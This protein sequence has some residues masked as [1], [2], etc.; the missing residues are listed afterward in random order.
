M[1][2]RTVA[3]RETTGQETLE[4]GAGKARGQQAEAL[5]VAIL[6]EIG[7]RL[8]P[9]RFSIWFKRTRLQAVSD[10]EITV[11]VPNLII[12]QYIEHRYL[13]T[14]QEAAGAVLGRGVSA[15]LE[16]D[17]ALFRQMREERARQARTDRKREASRPGLKMAPPP[18]REPEP[19][20]EAEETFFV[21]EFNR[22]AHAAMLEFVQN[23]GTKFRFMAVYG[24][25]GTGKTAYLRRM[26][27]S[28]A[29]TRP[30]TNVQTLS[31]ESWTNEFFYCLQ[32]NQMAKFRRRYRTCDLLLLDDVHFLEGKKTPQ[33]ELLYTLKA[34]QSEGK[35]AVV[36]SL[37]PLV[38]LHT[39]LPG[40]YN[41][42]YSWLALGL[43]TLGFQDRTGLARELA[44][45]RD[46]T[47]T[48]ET[49]ALLAESRLSTVREIENSVTALSAHAAFHRAGTVTAPMARE[50]LKSVLAFDRPPLSLEKIEEVVSEK[51]RLERGALR[52]PSRRRKCCWP[53]QVAMFLGYRQLHTTLAGIGRHFGGRNHSTVKHAIK[54]VERALAT[55]PAAVRLLEELTRELEAC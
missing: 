2:R 12:K 16:V 3:A 50:A 53:R 27:R 23:G 38:D 48:E 5:W 41:Y 30:R 4:T 54:A 47:C 20:E 14:V 35:L 36:T 45:A 39:F 46:V 19:P 49:L 29:E 40:L 52:G 7:E 44:A 6:E 43:G 21:G 31:A 55:Q 8:G 17:A 11:G 32:H 18:P 10:A 42:L 22:L 34:L 37:K 13:P 25:H 26:R 15:R 9:E 1:L 51:F 28:F 24:A 33:E